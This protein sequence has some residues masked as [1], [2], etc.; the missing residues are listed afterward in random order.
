MLSFVQRL[1]AGAGQTPPKGASAPETRPVKMAVA[2]DREPSHDAPSHDEHGDA[3]R[4]AAADIPAIQGLRISPHGSDA[5]LV[6][7]SNR[8]LLAECRTAPR[9]G[10]GVTAHFVGAFTPASVRGHVVR[11]AVARM[12]EDGI[13]YH[14]GIAFDEPISIPAL[15]PAAQGSAEAEAQPGG[16]SHGR[17]PVVSVVAGP[18]NRW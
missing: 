12:T 18:V 6:N 5:V 16:P 2:P 7:I 14:V 4:L 17:E 9:R 11:T 13:R 8:G 15:M 3:R 1:R 10:L